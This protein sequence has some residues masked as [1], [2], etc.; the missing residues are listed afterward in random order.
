MSGH[1]TSRRSST[2]TKALPEDSASVV[3]VD[4]M[5]RTHH[6]FSAAHWYS[7]W[8]RD[9][10]GRDA[11]DTAWM[12][13]QQANRDLEALLRLPLEKRSRA[14]RKDRALQ[15]DAFLWLLVD[16]VEVRLFQDP[17]E[18]EHYADLA[19]EAAE[20]RWLWD[21]CPKTAGLCGLTKAL[22]ANA[23]QRRN[24]LEEASERFSEGFATIRPYDE[25]EP[26]IV[27][28]M[29]SLHGRLLGFQGERQQAQEA[30]YRASSLMKKGGDELQR[31]RVVLHRALNWYAAGRDPY[32][33]LTLCIKALRRY[34]FAKNLLHSAH[35]SR[36]LARL[37]MTDRLTGTYLSEIQTLRAEMPPADSQFIV[38]NHQ[39]IDGIIAALAGDPLTGSHLLHTAARF[40]EEQ[41]LLSHSAIGWLE[42]AWAVLEIDSE[43]AKES[44]LI[45]YE[46]M[47]RSGFGGSEQQSMAQQIC[48]EAERYSLN[49]ETLRSGILLLAVSKSK[50]RL[51]P[52]ANRA[53][54][55]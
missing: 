18:S 6:D 48:F 3:T 9:R 52:S 45:A 46:Y 15:T 33:L 32:R 23:I 11:I 26:W 22:K 19:V 20:V 8:I 47:A 43:S 14:V 36:L 4:E 2:C 42:Y 21:R 27:G 31:L 13:W 30:L 55:A 28:R 25:I 38:A 16:C 49:R 54:E 35:I 17:A 41:E 39:Q 29:Y 12:E 10:L 53:S 1:A 34:P 37:Y 24:E 5:L 51:A 7:H 40:Y 44:A 50:A